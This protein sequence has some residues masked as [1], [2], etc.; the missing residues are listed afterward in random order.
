MKRNCGFRRNFTVFF[1]EF[2]G[3][4]VTVTA[5]AGDDDGDTETPPLT[6]KIKIS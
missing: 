3:I 6:A 5:A 2:C 1:T 4:Y